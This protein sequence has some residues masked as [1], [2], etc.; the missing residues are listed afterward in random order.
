MILALIQLMTGL[1]FPFPQLAVGAHVL[2]TSG[3]L[4][5]S[6]ALITPPIR[7]HLHGQGVRKIAITSQAHQAIQHQFGVEMVGSEAPVQVFG[8]QTIFQIMDLA[9]S[10]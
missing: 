8:C 3:G 1:R 9:F 6:D 5:V 7:D 2:P 4:L 10:P